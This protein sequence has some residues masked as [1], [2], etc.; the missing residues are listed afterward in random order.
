MTTVEH[1]FFKNDK[2]YIQIRIFTACCKS[3]FIVED[4]SKDKLWNPI[5]NDFLLWGMVASVRDAEKLYNEN[6]LKMQK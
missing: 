2:K 6:M 5:T 1:I 3:Q 4:Q